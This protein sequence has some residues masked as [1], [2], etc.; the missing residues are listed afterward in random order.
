MP[1]CTMQEGLY[2]SRREVLVYGCT[3]AKKTS[4]RLLRHMALLQPLTGSQRR[5]LV[6]SISWC[7]NLQSV[8]KVRLAL[9]CAK[10]FSINSALA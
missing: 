2:D 9:Y 6:V 7:A 10:I 8:V 5:I 4:K 3:R 1:L